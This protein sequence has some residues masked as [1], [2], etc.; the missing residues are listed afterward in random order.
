MSREATDLSR[1]PEWGFGS[2]SPVWWGTLGFVA[3]EGAAFVPAIGAHLYLWQLNQRW[4][5]SAAPPDLL[6][7]TLVLGMLLVSLVPNWWLD[8]AAKRQDLHQ[9]RLGIVV[10]TLLSLAPLVVRG[11]EFSALEVRW[12]ENA[13]GSMLWLLLGLH[14]MHLGTDWGDTAVLAVLMFTRHAHGK[15]FS[16][17]SDNCFYWYFVVAAWVPLWLLIYILPRL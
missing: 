5:L 13:Y 4:P 10:M 17:V 8:R 14:T 7:G 6:P 12:D 16:D 1:L 15:R 11:F 3:I 2:R 9:V